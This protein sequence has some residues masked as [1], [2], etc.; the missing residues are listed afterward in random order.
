MTV[1]VLGE[2]SFAMAVSK[3]ND[4]P[5]KGW[6]Y[7]CRAILRVII[8]FFKPTYLPSLGHRRVLVLGVY[9]YCLL[10]NIVIEYF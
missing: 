8:I 10:I 1:S 3:L 7:L 5:E 6:L 4:S 9:L 2:F